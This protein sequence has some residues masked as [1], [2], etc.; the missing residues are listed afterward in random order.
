MTFRDE[1]NKEYKYLGSK[2]FSECYIP[3]VGDFARAFGSEND[4]VSM[5]KIKEITD[6]TG[7]FDDIIESCKRSYADY[8]EAQSA[9]FIDSVIAANVTEIIASGMLYK[10]AMSSS[11]DMEIIEEDCGSEGFEVILPI[12]EVEYNY[13][14]KNRFIVELNNYTED[15]NLFLD[16]TK[17]L[18][19]IH[20]RTFLDCKSDDNHRKFC[21]KCSGLFRRSKETEFSPKYIGPYA[22]LMVTEKATQASLDSM[23]KGKSKSVT[24]M[25][26]TSLDSVNNYE[27]A[28]EVIRKMLDEIGPNSGVESRFY[29]LILLSRNYGTEFAPLNTSF[30]RQSDL[31][32]QFIYRPKATIEKLIKV[33]ESELSSLK[34]QI[35]FDSFFGGNSE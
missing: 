13:K 12:D 3:N 23:N 28:K 22:T 5:N 7:N 24:E 19:K 11:D 4:E 35:V 27:E 20:V 8:T 6:F 15:F 9:K 16:A 18:E 14:I 29:E 10:Y 33:G 25:L 34:S 1:Y 21:K 17:D 31:F 2:M 30:L 32:G 26:N